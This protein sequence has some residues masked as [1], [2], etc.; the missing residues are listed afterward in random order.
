MKRLKKFKIA[1]LKAYQEENITRIRNLNEDL[2]KLVNGGNRYGESR[3]IARAKLTEVV[4]HYKRIRR[5]AAALYRVFD[6]K[7]RSPHCSCGMLHLA[8]LQLEIRNA[9]QVQKPRS[10]VQFRFL[11][12]FDPGP[13]TL[14]RSSA[15]ELVIEKEE[16][17]EN[18]QAEV[19]G[20]EQIP[21]TTRKRGPKSN[22]WK[23]AIFDRGSTAR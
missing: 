5:H 3:P 15:R 9:E 13:E 23:P 19:I 4:E 7:L 17:P 16:L 22:R 10:G 14:P 20:Y 18:A 1:I 8:N 6:G 21:N 11:I 12:S 2:D